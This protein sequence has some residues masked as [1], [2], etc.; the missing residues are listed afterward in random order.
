MSNTKENV[1]VSVFKVFK[2]F[3]LKERSILTQLNTLK[4][5]KGKMYFEGLVWVPSHYEFASNVRPLIEN[6]AGFNYIKCTDVKG[7]TK[8]TLFLVNEFLWPFQEIVNTY[9]V[10]NYKEV[11]PALF[12]VISFQL[13]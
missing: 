2:L 7:L 13:G 5:E 9:G 11:N 10:P 3:L 1:E 6:M 4:H 8:P 12:S